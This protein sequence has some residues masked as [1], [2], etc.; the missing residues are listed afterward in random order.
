MYMFHFY[1]Q[2]YVICQQF[3]NQKW[4]TNVFSEF[5]PNAS[6]CI[7]LQYTYIMLLSLTLSSRQKL[8]GGYDGFHYDR[9]TAL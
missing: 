8:Q 4:F 9:V 7:S 6:V 5:H 3:V 2:Q 1:F